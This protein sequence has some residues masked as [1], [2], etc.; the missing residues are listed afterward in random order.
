M[1]S[2]RIAI[3]GL[4][5]IGL[6]LA[7]AFSKNFSVIGYDHDRYRIKELNSE[8]DRTLEVENK[9]DLDSVKFTNQ[10]SQLKSCNVFIIQFL[11]Q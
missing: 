4:G 7:V 8:T 3:V 11:L 2:E 6:P 9:S 5:Y 10:L 1:S